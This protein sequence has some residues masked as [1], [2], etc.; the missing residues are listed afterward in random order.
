MSQIDNC[1]S[2]EGAPNDFNLISQSQRTKWTI[3]NDRPTN[4]F[5]QSLSSSDI[6]NPTPKLPVHNRTQHLSPRLNDAQRKVVNER[7][8]NGQIRG[9][10]LSF[11]DE[12]SQEL[13]RPQVLFRASELSVF[14]FV[15]YT[16]HRDVFSLKFRC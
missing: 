13:N 9:K 10:D 2:I 3:V 15:F 6:I 12:H 14:L 11:L 8:R 7:G 5:P 4:V 16:D 1:R